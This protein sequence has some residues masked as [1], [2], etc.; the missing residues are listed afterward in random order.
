MNT[1]GDIY[2]DIYNMSS[3]K[4]SLNQRISNLSALR[5]SG[6]AIKNIYFNSP[7]ICKID[8]FLRIFRL[9]LSKTTSARI[10]HNARGIPMETTAFVS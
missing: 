2:N 6:S 9:S 4:P 7:K 5:G 8:V 10:K 3:Y 1:Q